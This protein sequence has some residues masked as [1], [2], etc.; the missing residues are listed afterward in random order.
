[1][2]GQIKQMIDSIVDQRAKGNLTIALTTKAKLVLK[3]V[4][5]SAFDE[6]SPDDPE[7]VARI[8]TIAADFGLCLLEQKLER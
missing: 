3:G 7:V 8:R 2:A 4:N 6:T 5:P 1:M